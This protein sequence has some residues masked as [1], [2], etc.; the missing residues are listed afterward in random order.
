MEIDES[1][2]KKGWLWSSTSQSYRHLTRLYFKEGK[3]QSLWLLIW[4]SSTLNDSGRRLNSSQSHF[5]VVL[6]IA[7]FRALSLE[8]VNIASVC[9]SCT[10]SFSLSLAFSPFYLSRSLSG[11]TCDR[12]DYGYKLLNSSHLDGCVGCDCDPVG[13]LSPF[14]EPEG[15][16]CECREGVGG[17]RCDS[18]ARGLY[19]LHHTGSCIPCLCSPDGTVPG[20]VCDPETGQCVC[21]VSV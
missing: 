2:C 13:S 7:A 21:K 4:T 9:L 5:V 18:C 3:V 17:Q 6:Q 14:C 11:L 8:R 12:C 16:Q 15:G 19:G 1:S 10:L 20:T